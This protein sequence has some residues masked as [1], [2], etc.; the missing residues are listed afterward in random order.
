MVF[1]GTF[2]FR[3]LSLTGF[4]DDHYVHVAGAQ[5]MRAGEW[6]TRDFVDP[7]MPLMYAT[8]AAMQA[9]LGGGLVT[10]ALLIS[11]AF[12]AAAAVTMMLAW[13]LT[14]SWIAALIAVALQVTIYPRTYSYPKI[15]LYALAVL[16]IV[17]YRERPGVARLLA[18]AVL[19]VVAFLFRHDHGIFIGA[20]A[21]AGIVLVPGESIRGRL[22]AARVY[23]ALVLALVAPYVIYVAANG[24]IGKYIATAAMFSRAEAER[25]PPV[26]ARFVT[27][28]ARLE[29]RC[30]G[31]G[32]WCA[33][34]VNAPAVL[35]YAFYALPIVA[36]LMLRSLDA[37][38]IAPLV[39]LAVIVDLSFL[40]DALRAR[41]ADAV[42]PA[43]LLLAVVLA[44]A[45]RARRS[46][47]L[48]MLARTVA[49][50]ACALL[51]TSS[52][53]LGDTRGRTFETRL[54]GGPIAM[55]GRVNEQLEALHRPR[56]RPDELSSRMVA[57]LVPY[58]DY[59]DRCLADEHR[60]F[61]PGFAPDVFVYAGRRFAGGNMWIIPGYFEDA[62]FQRDILR[63]LDAQAVP[64]AIIRLPAHEE[65]ARQ[66]PLIE[67]Y[68]RGRFAPLADAPLTDGDSIRLLVNRSLRPTRVDAQTRWP[69]YR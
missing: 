36:L 17:A 55:A 67:N 7:G 32:F 28:R 5:Q 11:A 48:T 6:P 37:A 18:L 61:V 4:T 56:E 2:T 23:V 15:L 49:V 54:P 59:M 27:T 38:T 68:L 14:G 9:V 60:L 50:T 31:N 57:G 66:F 45:W 65:I 13:R 24:G 10:E 43:S 12:A 20:A 47:A 29:Q 64:V 62:L 46:A 16:A 1:V 22:R 40:R 21:L 30:G 39:L 53:L 63:R 42:A 26:L 3:F 58:F 35:Y 69:C 44:Q 51:L 33:L 52:A 19:A 8:S 34:D 41:V 25:N